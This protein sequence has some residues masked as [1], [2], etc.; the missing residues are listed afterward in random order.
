MGDGAAERNRVQK[1]LEDANVKLA[2]EK[3]NA[4]YTETAALQEYDPGQ[5]TFELSSD[6]KRFASC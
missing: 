5:L 4:G 2:F 6:A 1:V 3:S